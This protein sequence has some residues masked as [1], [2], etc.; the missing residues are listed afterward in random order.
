MLADW[1]WRTKKEL[2]YSLLSD[3]E[4]KFI[5]KLGAFVQPNK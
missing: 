3:P 2:N 1:Q 5:K 4:S